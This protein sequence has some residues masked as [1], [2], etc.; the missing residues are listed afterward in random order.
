MQKKSAP[1]MES[2]RSMPVEAMQ[3][4]LYELHVHQIELEMQNEELRLTQVQLDAER[5]RYFDLYDLAPVGYCTVGV[6]G[7][8]QQ[9]NLTAAAMLG[10][11]RG[12]LVRRRIMTFIAQEDQDVYHLLRQNLLKADVPQSCELRMM[13]AG[14]VPFWAMISATRAQEEGGRPMCRIVLNDITQQKKTQENLRISAIA[15]E[16]QAGIAVVDL[17]QKILQVNQ[18]FAKIT[19]YNQSEILGESTAIFKSNRHPGAVYDAFWD[20]IKRTGECQGEIWQRRKNGSDF[21]AQCGAKA[22]RDEV[23][24]VTHYVINLT[25]TTDR[26]QQEQQR[27][28]DEAAHHNS[29]VREVHH[30][31]KNNLQG[32]LGIL[33]KFANR[34]PD[35]AGPM[36]QAI[37]QVQT[38]SVIHGLQGR[39]VMSSVYLHELIEAIANEIQ[40]LWQTPVSLQVLP[41]LPVHVVAEDESVPIALVLNELILNAVKHGGQSQGHVSVTLEQGCTVEVVQVKISNAGWFSTE[42]RPSDSAKSG[43]HLIS[44]LMPRHG[45]R[46]V[47]EQ[48]EGLVMTMLELEPPVILLDTKELTCP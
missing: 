42:A 31:I 2:L 5:A 24:Q 14:G 30:R 25:D 7:T 41:G 8:I 18:V 39:A 27:L 6:D 9:A 23:G 21:L 4:V 46:I 44:A 13:R 12:A 26:Q 11:V 40:D 17:H 10:V 22:V 19:G 15:F 33:R 34:H 3:Q 48:H 1:S 36:H 47:R 29:L 43:L 35:L 20:E 28:H 45:A 37:A 16:C 38:I 32:I